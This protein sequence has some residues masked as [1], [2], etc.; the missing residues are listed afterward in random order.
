MD[1]ENTE[2]SCIYRSPWSDLYCYD[3]NQRFVLERDKYDS[4]KTREENLEIC[5]MIMIKNKLKCKKRGL[6]PGVK[7]LEFDISKYITSSI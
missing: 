2:W 1:L 6:T 5:K 3:N 4:K 7:I